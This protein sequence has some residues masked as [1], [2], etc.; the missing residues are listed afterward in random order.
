MPGSGRSTAVAREEPKRTPARHTAVPGDDAAK[1]TRGPGDGG[2][3]ARA[4]HEKKTS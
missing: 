2:K 1:A 4:G 3:A